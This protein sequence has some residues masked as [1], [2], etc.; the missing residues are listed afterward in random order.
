MSLR[1]P[2]LQMW[3]KLFDHPQR[4]AIIW[5]LVPREPHQN[6]DNRW[7]YRVKHLPD[8]SLQRPGLDFYEN[9][10]LIIDHVTKRVVLS[11]A[12]HDQG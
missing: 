9:F 7:V 10:I 4:Q 8:V 3:F 2:N 6:L 5:T 12:M 1:P 11:I